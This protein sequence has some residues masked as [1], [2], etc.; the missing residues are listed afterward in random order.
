MSRKANKLIFT[1]N[2]IIF[3]FKLMNF[4]LSDSCGLTEIC[5]YFPLLGIKSILIYPI[6]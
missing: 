1:R 5:H 4:S 2:A 3:I 6:Q